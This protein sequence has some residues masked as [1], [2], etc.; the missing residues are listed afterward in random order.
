MCIGTDLKYKENFLK[1][2]KFE[3]EI[4]NLISYH[5]VILNVLCILKYILFN[6]KTSLKKIMYKKHLKTK[7]VKND[8]LVSNCDYLT[9]KW[10][11]FASSFLITRYYITNLL[12]SNTFYTL[13]SDNNFLVQ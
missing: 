3:T 10:K 12:N 4:K 7:T 9:T 2:K 6:N 8:T 11:T 5:Y 1:F 13:F